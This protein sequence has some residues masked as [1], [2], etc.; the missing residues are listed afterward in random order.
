M[1]WVKAGLSLFLVF[2]LFCVLLVPNSDNYMGEFFLKVTQ[3]Y[4]FFLELTNTWNF[5]APN[6]EPPIYIDY[7]LIDAQGQPYFSGRWPDIKE[8]YFCA[9]DRPGW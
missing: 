6:P 7:Q 5:F 8:P 4:L 9:S 3:P 1:K 2:H